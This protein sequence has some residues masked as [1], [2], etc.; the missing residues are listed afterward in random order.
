VEDGR[1]HLWE[2]FP[3]RNG[4]VAVYLFYYAEP[5]TL[6]S[7]PLARLYERFAAKLGHYKRGD[8]QLVRPTFGI[9]P[10]H[11]RLRPARQNPHGRIVLVGDA[12]ARQSPLTF[13]GFGAMLRSLTGACEGIV[14]AV[15]GD[16]P[17]DSVVDD[18]PVHQV[19]GALALMLARA[20]R[21]DPDKTNALLNAAF[22]TLESRGSAV[23]NAL[24]QDCMSQD[25]AVRFV[26]EVGQRYPKVW[27][28]VLRQLGPQNALR[29]AWRLRRPLA[30][31]MA[32]SV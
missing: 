19:T 29:W 7:R 11:S 28:A 20:H 10:G 13:C 14:R 32:A 5:H 18:A 30:N 17:K 12:A 8:W 1:Q 2:A 16:A 21:N 31:L 25:E 6:P 3:G 23:M 15:H 22:N 27:S 24:L 4:E 26:W 9:I